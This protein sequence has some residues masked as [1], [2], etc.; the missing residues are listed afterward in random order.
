M[1]DNIAEIGNEIC[2]YLKTIKEIKC[3]KIYG[4]IKNG[5]IDKYSDI[6]IEIDTSG[7]DN[8]VFITKIPDII[9]K[10]YPIIYYDYARSLMPKDY[11]VSLAISEENPFLIIDIKCAANPHRDTKK[12]NDFVNNELTHLIKLFVA[13]YKHYIRGNDSGKDISRMYKKIFDKE[14]KTEEMLIDTYNWLLENVEE[15]HE[16]YLRNIDI[17][18]IKGR[19]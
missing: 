17:E 9:N 8:S 3:C 10:K 14:E 6:D 13:N 18:I 5:N 16:R 4:S 15:K 1:K 12:E 11:I 19:G 2:N 7:Y